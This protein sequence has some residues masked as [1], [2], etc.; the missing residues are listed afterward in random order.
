MNFGD[1]REI[2]HYVPQF[3]G[4]TFVVALD[5]A[6]VESSDFSNILLDLAVLRS[7]SVRV[8][9]VHGAA[10]QIE[11]LGR[12]RGVALSNVDGTG[13]TDEA[14]LEVSMDAI[15]RLGNAVMQSLTTVKIKAASANAIH[16]HPAGILKGVDTGFTGTVERIDAGVLRGF[17]EQDILPVVPPLGFDADGQILRVNSDAV[18]REVAS[19]LGASKVLFVSLDDPRD[20]TGGRVRQWTAEEALAFVESSGG[21]P[22]GM[23]SKL[24]HGARATRDGVPRVHLVGSRTPDALLAELFSNEGVGIMVYS[25]AYQRIRQAANADID[26]LYLLI[27]RAIEEEQL[28]ER[29]RA[30][31]QAAI[32]DYIVVEID[33][34]IVGCVAVHPDPARGRAEL[35]CLF[36]KRGHTGQGYGGTLVAAAAE[37]ARQRGC[38][39]LFALST[40]AAGYLVR[41][42]FVRSHDLDILPPERREKWESNGRNA[43]LLVRRLDPAEDE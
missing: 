29:S 2:L 15:S 33:G 24:R 37:R 30:E 40:Q 28:I 38:G 8:V 25:D 1:L 22:P 31:I 35:A 41:E 16:A 39:E 27:H 26:E 12:K 42:G 10:A 21:L 11:A 7:L 32:D 43:L 36:V 19:A 23:V 14:T 18:A 13:V 4:R 6:V 3:R 20:H 5:G 34:N 17:L 9:L